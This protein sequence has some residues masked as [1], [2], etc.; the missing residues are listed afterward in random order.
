MKK[1]EWKVIPGLPRYLASTYGRIMSLKHLKIMKQSKSGNGYLN[2]RVYIEHKLSTENITKNVSSLIALTF[3]GNSNKRIIIHLNN[4]ITD[5]RV[6]NLKYTTHK[7]FYKSIGVAKTKLTKK[8]V[9]LIKRKIEEGMKIKDIV[10]FT[11]ISFASVS[12]VSKGIYTDYNSLR[13]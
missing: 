12:R 5:N 10:A 8:D 13:E 11:G 2:V 4:D 9:N 7:D 6:V 3:I 1:E